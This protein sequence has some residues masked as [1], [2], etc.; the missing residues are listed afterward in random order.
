MAADRAAY[1]KNGSLSLAEAALEAT[2]ETH[3][4]PSSM[5]LLALSLL[6]AASASHAQTAPP[7]VG[8]GF[9]VTSA[10]LSQDLIPDGP[11]LGVR[12]RVA[13]PVNRDVSVAGDLGL[14]AHIFEGSSEA[15]YVLN[16]QVSLIVTLPGDRSARYFLGGFGGFV[17]FNEGSGGPSLHAG[18]GW[19]IPLSETSLF[20]EVDP[21]LI[22][23][24]DETTPVLAVRGGVIF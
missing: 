6:L 5:R 22:V 9:E 13:L 14:G 4:P 19:A 20:V 12:G 18:M 10:F 21:S 24:E 7:R 17:P 3:L 16:P 8:A 23:G 15:R 1:F 2:T 11:A